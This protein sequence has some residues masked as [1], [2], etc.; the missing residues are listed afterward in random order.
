MALSS[1]TERDAPVSSRRPSLPPVGGLVALSRLSVVCEC[2]EVVKLAM[3]AVETEEH[4]IMAVERVSPRVAQNSQKLLPM[5]FV[6]QRL[7]NLHFPGCISM[8]CNKRKFFIFPLSI[9]R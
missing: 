2:Y 7:A 8:F 1:P 3:C 5:P 9:L 4:S 6:N